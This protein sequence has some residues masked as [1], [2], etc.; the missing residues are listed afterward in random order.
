MPTTILDRYTVRPVVDADLDDVVGLTDGMDRALGLPADPIRAFLIWIWHLPTTDLGRDTR[1]V[2]DGETVV[3]YG[4][5]IWT[6]EEG[7]P[8][9]LLARVHPE[10]QGAGI[11]TWL[12]AWGEALADERGSRGVRADV[13]DR[14][15]PGHELL[16]SRGYRPVRSSHTM[17]KDLVADED[18]WAVPAGV[19]I[20]PYTDADERTLY[21]IHEA[22]FSD[23]WGYRPTSFERFNEQMRGEDWDPTLVFLADHDGRTVGHIISFVFGDYGYVAGLGVVRPARGRGI[24]TALLR[25]TFVEIAARGIHE[26]RLEVDAQNPHGAVALYEGVGMTPRRCYDIFDL[27]TVEA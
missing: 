3:G 2:L 7:G 17:S 13:V 5:A 11:G 27:G 1:L 26:I 16:R 4:Q 25:R 14:D 21:E 10:H 20:R 18:E 8:L 22:S 19:T 15:E 6:P 12:L 24:A 23:H 9:Y